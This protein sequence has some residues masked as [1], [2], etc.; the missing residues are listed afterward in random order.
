MTLRCDVA[1]IGGSLAGSA[2]AAALARGGADVLVLEKARF[3]RPKICG[4]FLSHEALPVLERMGA[5]A[6]V[7]RAGPERIDRFAVV[8]TDGR[9]VEAPLAAP[10][11]SISRDRLDAIVARAAE[12]AG[13]RVTASG[14]F[15]WAL[16]WMRGGEAAAVERAS[17]A[18]GGA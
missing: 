9:S 15:A 18:A 13:A 14:P 12:D 11:L 7:S 16:T 3:P 8:R 17:A 4:E 1:V 2:A 10:V 5:L 6:E